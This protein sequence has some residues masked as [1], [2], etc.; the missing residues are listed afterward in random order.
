VFSIVNITQIYISSVSPAELHSITAPCKKAKLSL[1]MSRGQTVSN[2]WHRDIDPLG[3]KW[4]LV[5]VIMPLNSNPGKWY[6]YPLNVRLSGPQRQYGHPGK[7]KTTCS[8]GFE[9]QIIP[10][11]TS[12][13]P[14]MLS[15]LLNT[16]INITI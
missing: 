16:S 12:P 14:A 6:L 13:Y 5:I 15:Q 10:H 4:K 9:H 8:S 1:F 7:E 3:S 2:V 11:F